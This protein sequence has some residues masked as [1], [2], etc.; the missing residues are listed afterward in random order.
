MLRT[1]RNG[2]IDFCGKI[3]RTWLNAGINNLKLPFFKWFKS[4]MFQMDLI[5]TPFGIFIIRRFTKN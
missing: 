3:N 5:V 1:D 2:E 4:E